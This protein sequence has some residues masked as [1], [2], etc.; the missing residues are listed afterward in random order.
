ME[1]VYAHGCVQ[2]ECVVEGMCTRVCVH[3]G[4]AYTVYVCIRGGSVCREYVYVWNVV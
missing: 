4:F 3:R 1:N 2:M